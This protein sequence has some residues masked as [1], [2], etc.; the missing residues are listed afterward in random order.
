MASFHTHSSFAAQFSTAVLCFHRHSR[1]GRSFLELL[2]SFSVS[3]KRHLVSACCCLPTSCQLR[4][5]SHGLRGKRRQKRTRPIHHSLFFALAPRHPAPAHPRTTLA[6]LVAFVK[7]QGVCVGHDPAVGA[8]L[9]G[10]LEWAR[11]VA[12]TSRRFEGVKES[13]NKLLTT[14]SQ[15]HRGLK[16]KGLF[17]VP[18]CLC[19]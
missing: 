19:G 1:V 8:P 15:R 14:E 10:A 3:P 16:S 11:R 17:S 6:Y 12:H 9:V 4:F 2:S 18:L 7:R 5:P 13:W